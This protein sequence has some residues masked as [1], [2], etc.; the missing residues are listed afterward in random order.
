M[1]ADKH[2]ASAMLADSSNPGLLTDAREL[3]A[4]MPGSSGGRGLVH[5]V[6][7][8]SFAVIDYETPMAPVYVGAM[9]AVSKV[10]IALDDPSG[11]IT[12]VDTDD[13]QVSQVNSFELNSFIR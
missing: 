3:F 7:T 12:F 2:V 4:L 11:W 8:T 9:P 6:S 1:N 5:R 13:G 10:A